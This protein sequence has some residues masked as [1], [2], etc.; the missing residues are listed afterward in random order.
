MFL[1]FF[2]DFRKKKRF[3]RI[4]QWYPLRFFFKKKKC[5]CVAV[6]KK[7]LKKFSRYVTRDEFY[8]V[9]I[10]FHFKSFWN[11]IKKF[12]LITKRNI[13]NLI[14]SNFEIKLYKNEIKFVTY[15]ENFFKYFLPTATQFFFFVK[16]PQKKIYQIWMHTWNLKNTT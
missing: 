16:Q 14:K 5:E 13:F 2:K 9:F 3:S 4:N 6:G 11:K 7:Y 10:K 15:L 8:F 12:H 1:V